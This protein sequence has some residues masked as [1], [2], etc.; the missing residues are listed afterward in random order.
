MPKRALSPS[1]RSNGIKSAPCAQYVRFTDADNNRLHDAARVLGKTI[2]SFIHEATME[3]V[4]KTE[5]EYAESVTERPLSRANMRKRREREQNERAVVPTGLGLRDRFDRRRT[6][7]EDS[8]EEVPSP[9]PTTQVV[10]TTPPPTKPGSDIERFALYVSHGP[11]WNRGER[12]REATKILTATAKTPE[13]RNSI[14]KALDQQIAALEGRVAG[15]SF[16]EK[17]K[18]I[19]T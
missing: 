12:L 3:V 7:R 11:K 14:A 2:Q 5:R 17:V 6:E 16:L 8:A 15:E 10:V 19:F 4:R 18:G 9:T 1:S 13:E